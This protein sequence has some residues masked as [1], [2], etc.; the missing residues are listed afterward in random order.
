MSGDKEFLTIDEAA[1]YVGVKRG[2]LY[3]YI[4]ELGIETHKFRLDRRTYLS[5][6]DVER[7][8][9]VKEKPWLAGPDMGKPID[10]A[11]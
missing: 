2:T 3:N 4:N 7:I 1:A 5:R 6:A 9:E 11:A 8:K 10:E